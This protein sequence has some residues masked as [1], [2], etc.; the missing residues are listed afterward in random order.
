MPFA[1]VKRP[2]QLLIP[3]IQKHPILI[4]PFDGAYKCETISWDMLISN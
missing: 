2:T 4:A 3:I 1:Y